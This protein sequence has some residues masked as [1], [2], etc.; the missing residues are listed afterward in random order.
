MGDLQPFEEPR[1]YRQYPQTGGSKPP[2][3]GRSWLWIRVNKW[4]P[5]VDP[6]HPPLYLSSVE[7][8]RSDGIVF[9]IPITLHKQKIDVLPAPANG[10]EIAV[11]YINEALADLHEYRDC[12][13]SQEGPCEKHKDR[14]APESGS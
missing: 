14:M 5:S 1:G 2:G 13:C 8:L 11:H 6:R 4:T 9:G 12:D 10:M 3:P 7:G